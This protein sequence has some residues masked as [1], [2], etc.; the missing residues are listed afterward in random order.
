MPSLVI[1]PSTSAG[2]VGAVTVIVVPTVATV[3]PFAPAM[4]KDPPALDRVT[5]LVAVARVC[6]SFV[7]D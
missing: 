7:A 5:V 1:L 6:S 2:A 3:F 4:V